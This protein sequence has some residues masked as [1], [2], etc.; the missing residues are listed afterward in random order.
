ML[1]Q[2]P[3]G[4]HI[5]VTL[6]HTREGV[7]HQLLKDMRE[8]AAELMANPG[9]KST[10]QAAVYGMAQALPDRSMVGD[11]AKFYLDAYYS[12]E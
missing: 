7:A 2:F 9:S 8:V 5:C 6:M 11:I 12:T 3:S 1:L 4:F 10:G